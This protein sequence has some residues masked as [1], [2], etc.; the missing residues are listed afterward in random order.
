LRDLAASADVVRR[1]R[2]EVVFQEGDACDAL[3][4]IAAGRVR[5][6]KQ[7]PEGREQVLHLEES[8]ALGE[9]PLI[10]GGP[11][12]ASA[13]V[14]ED[15]V[16]LRL[17]RS[18]VLAWCRRHGDLALGIAAVLARRVRRFATIAEMHNCKMRH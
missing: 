14:A 5:I 16:L 18:T 9:V 11:F 1:R 7:S 10:D 2:R 3:Y 8:G 4:V 12:P 6:L 13:D 17:P 15:T